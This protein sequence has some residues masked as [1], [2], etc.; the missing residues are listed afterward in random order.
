MIDASPFPGEG[1]QAHA[2]FLQWAADPSRRNPRAWAR[3]RG[4]NVEQ[5]EG[6]IHRY[7]WLERRAAMTAELDARAARL[8]L[9]RDLGRVDI[10]LAELESAGH[11][12]EIARLRLAHLRRET[13]EAPGAL[14][15]SAKD[16]AALARGA[17]DSA[18]NLAPASDGPRPTDDAGAL[19]YS[20]LST[21]QLVT[22]RELLRL[23]RGGS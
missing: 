14:D 17:G 15:L 12:A 11:A 21:E 16:A 8:V 20:R 13:R 18:R 10:E 3:E 2:A 23:A 22:L 9:L 19:D 4:M 5:V 7:A 1:A 6:W